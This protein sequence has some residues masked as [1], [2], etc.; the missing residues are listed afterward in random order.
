MLLNCSHI[1]CHGHMWFFFF[2]KVFYFDK[3]N[4][5][6][7]YHLNKTKREEKKNC[8]G[9]EEEI[10]KERVIKRPWFGQSTYCSTFCFPHVKAQCDS[11]QVRGTVMGQTNVYGY[12]S[13]FALMAKI[14]KALKKLNFLI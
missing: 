14:F 2:S 12:F 1:Q 8:E 10:E 11:M 4:S 9:E 13:F 7:F 6:R 5:A 3:R